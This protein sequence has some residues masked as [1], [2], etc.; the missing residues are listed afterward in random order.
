CY[1]SNRSRT[2]KSLD[3][4][5]RIMAALCNS[6]EINPRNEMPGHQQIQYDKQDPG[7]LLAAAGYGRNDIAVLD[8]LVIKHMKGDSPT[9]K[10]A[11]NEKK[12]VK[13]KPL[14]TVWAWNGIFTSSKNNMEPIVDRRAMGLDK[15]QVDRGSW[16]YPGEFV[17]FDQVIKD[18]INSLWWIR[19]KYQAV[20]ANKKDNFFMAIAE[21]T[22]KEEKLLKEKELWGE[23]VLK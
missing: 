23:I 8:N 15:A 21:I 13:G 4:T 11:K 17:K 3:N 6:W 20:G 10:V 19:F 16:I 1:F 14:R 5:C 7:N 9:P 12:V 18:K 2:F 22:D